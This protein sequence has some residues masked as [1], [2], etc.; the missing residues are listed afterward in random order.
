VL[1]STA[2]FED[3]KSTILAP[4]F[5]NRFLEAFGCQFIRWDWL[6]YT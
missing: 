3:L 4:E 1:I 2:V 5:A 6:A